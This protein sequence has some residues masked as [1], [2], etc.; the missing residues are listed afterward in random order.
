MLYIKIENAR[1]QIP[2]LFFAR[3]C[4]TPK[5]SIKKRNPRL[6]TLFSLDKKNGFAKKIPSVARKKARKIF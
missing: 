5:M 2:R 3:L 4:P 1:F 6:I